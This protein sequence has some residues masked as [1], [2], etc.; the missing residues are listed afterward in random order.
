M[1]FEKGH[2]KIAGRKPATPNRT[3]EQLRGLIQAFVEAN[4]DRIQEDFDVLKPNE[5]LTFLNSLLRHVLPEPVS[6]ER[7][8]EIQLEQLQE[9]LIKKY[10]DNQT[11]KT[12]SDKTNYQRQE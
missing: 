7:L 11:A 4:L 9:F 3:T 8:S 2:K 12:G 6:L 5:R 10:H 1:P